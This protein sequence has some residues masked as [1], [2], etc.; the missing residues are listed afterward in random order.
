M[1]ITWPKWVKIPC[2]DLL[3]C[4]SYK[5]KLGFFVKYFFERYSLF[6]VYTLMSTI[7]KAVVLYSLVQ[8]CI[9]TSN[10]ELKFVSVA[11]DL[12][13]AGV[14]FISCTLLYIGIASLFYSL[15]ARYDVGE[16]LLRKTKQI[17]VWILF[18]EK[19]Y[20]IINQNSW[21]K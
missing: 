16:G 4:L 5:H 9:L 14:G 15:V 17:I 19:V 8:N 11:V 12:W 2:N 3:S 6:Y 7:S 20:H 21:W 18:N 1:Q 13:V 10:G